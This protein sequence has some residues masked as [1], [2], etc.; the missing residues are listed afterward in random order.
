MVM[1]QNPA[2]NFAFN[3]PYI[4]A[5]LTTVVTYGALQSGFAGAAALQAINDPGVGLA[6]SSQQAFAGGVYLTLSA[7]GILRGLP[8]LVN[9]FASVNRQK[10]STYLSAGWALTSNIGPSFAGET[11]GAV[12][13]AFQF[14]ILLTQ[15][16]G[17]AASS[18]Y[19]NSIEARTTAATTFNSSI[20]SGTGG[21][22][23]S[24]NSLWVTPSGAVVT[25]GGSLVSGSVKK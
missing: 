4:T 9:S 2:W 11:V 14:G 16:L 15:T 6:Y 12:N 23:P 13:D 24:N 25:W 8:G 3:H 19:S 20:G 7:N 18:L 1:G 21:S 22:G 17:V 5:A 10:P